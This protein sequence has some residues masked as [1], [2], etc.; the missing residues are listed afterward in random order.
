MDLRQ[1]NG[2]ANRRLL[3]L[4]GIRSLSPRRFAQSQRSR[5]P[6]LV[7]MRAPKSTY[8]ESRRFSGSVPGFRVAPE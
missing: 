2:A 5:G 7:P 8:P 1:R 3:L 6:T 4:Q